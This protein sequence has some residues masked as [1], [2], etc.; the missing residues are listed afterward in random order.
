MKIYEKRSVISP[1]FFQKIF[2]IVPKINFLIELEN[3]LAENESNI[4]SVSPSD[5]EN[6]KNKY[7]VKDGSFKEERQ[8]LLEKY[9]VFCVSDSRLSDDEKKQLSFLCHEV[10]GLDN[11]YLSS[12]I[13]DLGA[14]IYRGKV[15]SVISDDVLTDS[16]REKLKTLRA[17]FNLTDENGKDIYS[18]ECGKKIQ[19]YIDKLVEK[20]RMSP[21]EEK[22]LNDMISGLGINA[23]FTD[24]GLS[25]LRRFWEIESGK[26]V[27]I[28]TPLNLQKN[29]CPYYTS[30]IRWYEERL[31]TTSVS[32]GGL[33]AKFRICKGVSL[34]A[35]NIAPARHSEEY[36]K[37]IDSGNVYFTNKR[38]IF[39]GTHGNKT[40][41]WSKVL[42]FTP[43]ADGIEVGKDTGKKPFFKCTDVETMGLF[44]ARLLKDC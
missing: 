5:V 23:H 16:E 28:D 7:K 13:S 31:R 20:R 36:M 12:R 32:Y 14:S 43:Y 44:I 1:S 11:D 38:I 37:L 22:T 15:Q 9:L 27:P 30:K 6:L 35:G 24:A 2:K 34:R 25:K 29:E 3:L 39:T 41:P 26:L 42:D 21:D 8:A 18:E 33:N 40:I 19:A 17:E 10:L 4:L